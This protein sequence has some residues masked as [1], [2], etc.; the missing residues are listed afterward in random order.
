MNA[1]F[2]FIQR[3]QPGK[4]INLTKCIADYLEIKR[5][6]RRSER[7]IEA[8]E[9]TLMQFAKWYERRTDDIITTGIMREYIHY[10][11]FE[12]EKWDDHP[13]NKTGSKGLSARS[14]NNTIRNLRVFFNYLVGERI[15]SSSPMENIQYQKDV[16][17]TFE[18]FSDDDV[19]KLLDA[20]N[21]RTFTGMRDYTMMLVL[22]DTM[23]RIKELTNLRVSDVDFKFRQITIRAE[24]SKTGSTRV[25]P[26][27]QKT[28]K[29]LKALIQS[30]N[31]NDDDYL[32]L[33]QFGE[34]YLA[35]TFSKMLKNYGKKVG[36][37]GVRV[38]PHTF[39]HY[40]AIKYLRSNGDPISLMKILGHTS[41][42]MT[43]RYVRFTSSD[44]REQHAKA[45][46]VTNLLD[47]GNSRKS[48][49]V[50]FR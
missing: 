43:E 44:I 29:A 31:V 47:S 7:T 46:P 28:A 19:R 11:T 20:P 33:T 21:T 39:R 26:I 2:T 45:S 15:L 38:S 13:T 16:K 32:W 40:G 18:I 12:K 23:C 10:L 27:S 5:I 34:R 9:Q 30:M 35:D 25:I 42:S 8:Y 1:K 24:I 14:I 4:A 6:A 3:K 50:R 48:G 22:V 17:D 49:Q 37:T 36:V 41:L